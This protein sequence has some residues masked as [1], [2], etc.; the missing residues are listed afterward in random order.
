MRISA[1]ACMALAALI[2]PAACNKPAPPAESAEFHS[3]ATEGW[4]YG[5]ELEFTPTPTPA[6]S[7]GTGRIAIAV[8]H[9][10]GYLYSNLWLELATP[11]PETDSMKLDT[12]NILLADVYGRWYGRGVGVSYVTIDTLAGKYAYDTG[13]PAR[14]RHI[15]RADTLRDIEQ[16]GI[17]LFPDKVKPDTIQ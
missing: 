12:V 17:I 7:C 5:T 2:M 8:R 6:D 1:Y 3:I 9:T 16:V 4:A 13:R 15:M 14:L 10:N 11:V